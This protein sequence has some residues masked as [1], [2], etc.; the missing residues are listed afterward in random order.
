MTRP[1]HWRSFAFFCVVAVAFAACRVNPDDDPV[2]IVT[3]PPEFTVDLFEQRDATDGSPL[4]GLWVESMATF[5]CSGYGIDAT[6][7]VQNNRIAVTLLGIVPATPCAGIPAH[8]RQFLPIG[9]LQDGSYEFSLSLRD[10]IV[11]NGTLT[12]ANGHYMLSLPDQQGIDFQNL[13]LEHMPD[14]IVWGYAEVPNETTKPVADN[15]I[16]DLKKITE[17]PAL[18][19]GFYSY[20][21]VSGTGNVIFHKRIAPAGVAEQFVRRLA[22]APDALKSLLQNYRSATQPSLQIRCLTTAGEL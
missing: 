20:F 22:T 1:S 4:F 18:P 6:V 5:D 17:D 15:F 13:V 12:I 9:N 19:P 7:S 2:I 3:T 14:G 8:A 11:N 16:F 10:A 21:T